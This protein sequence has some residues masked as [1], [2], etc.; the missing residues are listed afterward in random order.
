[1][2]EVLGSEGILVDPRH[3][4]ALSA[5]LRRLLEDDSLQNRARRAASSF[6]E[7][8]SWTRCVERTVALY[9]EVSG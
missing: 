8:F 3:H 6:G 4:A 2:A 7:T 1:M 9:Q 5:G